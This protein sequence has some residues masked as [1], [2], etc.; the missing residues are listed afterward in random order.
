MDNYPD[1]IKRI[2]KRHKDFY[3]LDKPD[4]IRRCKVD[5]IY[6]GD[7]LLVNENLIWHSVHK[8]IGK[9]EALVKNNCVEKDDILQLGR[10]GFLKAMKA[11][12]LSRGVKFSSFAVTAIV[13]EIRC[14]LR[15]SASIIRPTRTAN[16]LIN[17]IN[18][19]EHELAYMPSVCDLAYL[20]DED[21][22]K[23][24]KALQ[25]GQSVKYLDEPLRNSGASSDLYVTRMDLI[26]D[27]AGIEDEVL[28]K[29]YVDAILSTV[30]KKLSEKEINV[31]KHRIEGLNQTQTAEKEG[32]S[33][34]R[35]SR[36]MKK[37]A[38]MLKDSDKLEGVGS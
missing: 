29:V 6:L 30:K 25:V 2:L 32:I 7:A 26:E 14:F 17:R 31:L 12:D 20:L 13:R 15:D 5:E 3:A 28:D 36:I 19:I 35:V 37:V 22:E 33:Q 24:T 8:Y 21:E 27:S 10:L 9:P 34:M 38:R 16:D 4:N 11:F 1:H 23:I 18:R